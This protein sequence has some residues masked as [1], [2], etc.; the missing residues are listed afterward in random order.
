MLKTPS[1]ENT[2]VI[3]NEREK[4]YIVDYLI[5]DT[6][7]KGSLVILKRDLNDSSDSLI[8]QSVGKTEDYKIWQEQ[9]K[10]IL[11]SIKLS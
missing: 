11:D 7:L 2:E 1:F 10:I 3:L 4:R 9:I 5:S 6:G 8:I